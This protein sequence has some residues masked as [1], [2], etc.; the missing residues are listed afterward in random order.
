MNG[1]VRELDIGMP[2]AF[3]T[4]KRQFSMGGDSDV[5]IFESLLKMSPHDS[6]IKLTLL[7]STPCSMLTIF[8]MA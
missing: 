3:N 4:G 7:G 2:V 6:H 8:A 5:L 1:M